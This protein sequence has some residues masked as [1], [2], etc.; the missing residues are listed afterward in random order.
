MLGMLEERIMKSLKGSQTEKNILT[1]FAG[2]SQAR[3]RYDF[4]SGVAKK[5]GFV[6]VEEIFLETACQEREHAKRLFKFLE[7]G[8]VEIQA[9]YPSGV[10]AGSEANL[11]AAAHGENYEHTEMYPSMAATAEKEGFAEVAFAMRHIAVAEAYHE[12]RFLKLA[13]D[14]KEGRMFLRSKPTVW[15]CLNCGC[16]VE[17]D[18]APEMCPA[19]AHP[20][21]YFEELN[22]CF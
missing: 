18:H 11:L 15:R 14:I 12:K 20:K 9:A 19:C 2:E 5:D 6:L 13:S 7:G 3:N 22:Y 4:F 16:L 1:A 10:I 8:E 21:A 17:G